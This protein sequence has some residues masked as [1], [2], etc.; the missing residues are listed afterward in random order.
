MADNVRIGVTRFDLAAGAHEVRIWLVDPEFV[1][2]RLVLSR[3]GAPATYLGPPES[4]LQSAAT[5]IGKNRC[6]SAALQC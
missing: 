6:R 3:P 5:A 1:F 2:Q 4:A